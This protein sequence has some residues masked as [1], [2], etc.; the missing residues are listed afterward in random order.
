VRPSWLWLIL[1][2]PYIG[3]DDVDPI[4]AC[5]RKAVKNQLERNTISLFVVGGDQ[6]TV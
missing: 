5:M 3:L 6:T 1:V 4:S 2:I